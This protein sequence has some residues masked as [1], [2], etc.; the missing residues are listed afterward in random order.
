MTEVANLPKA[1]EPFVPSL[2]C[3]MPL[4]ASL[5]GVRITVTV[6]VRPSLQLNGAEIVTALSKGS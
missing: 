4:P 3:T 5:S 6:P 1:T 2:I